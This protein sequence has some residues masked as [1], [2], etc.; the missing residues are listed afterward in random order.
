MAITPT[1]LIAAKG[2][3]DGTA[4]GV[5]PALTEKISSFSNP[6]GLVGSI[7]SYAPA[8]LPAFMTQAQS[9]ISSIQAQASLI[10]PSGPGVDPA[11]AM[12]KFAG[13]FNQTAAFGAAGAEWGAAL[14]QFQGKSFTDLAP[15]FSKMSEMNTNGLTNMF[16]PPT[17]SLTGLMPGIVPADVMKEGIGK[18]GESMKGFG[19]MFS[20]GDISK[21]GDPRALVMNLKQQ[22]LSEIGGLEDHL[23]EAG[24]DDINDADPE[25]VKRVLA[26]IQGDDLKKL[27]RNTGFSPA[28]EIT[29]LAQVMDVTKILPAGV[30]SILPAGG[31]DGLAN[32]LGNLGGNFK[33]FDD[34]SST[35]KAIEVPQ[36][37]SLDALDKPLPDDVLAEFQ[38]LLGSGDGPFGN[39][40]ME[41]MLG[42]VSGKGHMEGFAEMG[43]SLQK[44]SGSP[45]GN[46]LM[47]SGGSLT[48]AVAAARANAIANGIPAD[49]EDQILTYIDTD[50]A[51]VA[52]KQNMD[53]VGQQ[54]AQQMAGNFD[55]KAVTDKANAAFQKTQAQLAK[56]QNNFGAPSFNPTTG[57]VTG[58]VGGK[59][60]IDLSAIPKSN[61]S[62][63]AMAS[64]LHN[65]GVD[66]LNLGFSDIFS[67]MSLPGIGGEAIQAALQEGRSRAKQISMGISL[68]GTAN[69]DQQAVQAAQESLPNVRAERDAAKA[70][71]ESVQRRV[72]RANQT[73]GVTST[74]TDE[75]NLARAKL[76]TAQ[77][78]VTAAERTAGVEFT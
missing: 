8:G 69:P 12:K 22:G 20:A 28:G 14:K 64:N 44:I 26:K 16:S 33:S 10:M 19:S 21:L 9:Q 13:V 2:L 5:S 38:D 32:S 67:K 40:T 41:D 65:F 29:N 43:I 73:S 35:F 15:N 63:L 1:V 18:L 34:I 54:F 47:Q 78:N 42:S 68:P 17:G 56:E 46:S 66:K 75:L 30:S 62:I 6:S 3:V 76:D 25:T 45:L 39:P 51:V 24:I 70:E 7:S 74:L 11:A 55:L 52:A 57:A 49:D 31:L 37:P 27:M 61:T 77:G 4:L 50:P 36:V 48:N 60:G 58:L 71:F 59:A 53:A 23:Y 72:Q